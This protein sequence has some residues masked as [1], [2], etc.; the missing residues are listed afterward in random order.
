MRLKKDAFKMSTIRQRWRD[1]FH[2]WGRVV[3]A[4]FLN[5][6]LPFL[7]KL[8]LYVVDVIL[9]FVNRFF[10]SHQV[11]HVVTP[12]SA[13]EEGSSDAAQKDALSSVVIGDLPAS[14]LEEPPRWPLLEEYQGRVSEETFDYLT[15]RL[16]DVAP[17]KHLINHKWAIAVV[18]FLDELRDSSA[19]WPLDE[20]PQIVALASAVEGYLEHCGYVCLDVDQWDASKQRAVATR[21]EASLPEMTILQKGAT[22]LMHQG[23]VIRKQE[24][25]VNQ[26]PA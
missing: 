17:E 7:Y 18:D 19:E 20:V 14:Q 2:Q 25:V 4:C 22:G 5:W 12:S 16:V 3:I 21:Y 1:V 11:E 9:Q 10:A 15:Y 23:E 13:T 26:T 24:V 6:V 8:W